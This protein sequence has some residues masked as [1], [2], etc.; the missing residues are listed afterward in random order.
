MRVAEPLDESY[1]ARQSRQR[2]ASACLASGGGDG[3]F[4]ARLRKA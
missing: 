3:F 1:G 2:V 4:Y